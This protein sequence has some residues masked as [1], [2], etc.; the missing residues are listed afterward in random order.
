MGVV[1]KTHGIRGELKVRPSC[2]SPAF[3]ALFKTLTVD[4]KTVTVTASRRHGR[5][6]LVQ[7]EGVDTVE[8]AMPYIGKSLYAETGTVRSMLPPGRHL[9]ADLIG[10]T[11]ADNDDGRVVGV[12]ANVLNMPRHDVYVINGKNG[13]FMVP[14][15]DEFIKDIDMEHRTIRV[16]LIAGMEP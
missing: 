7:L 1:S 10:C 14:V 16:K 8:A 5:A 3:L 12:I 6:L 2:D 11:V 13:E 9:I 15:V 4:G